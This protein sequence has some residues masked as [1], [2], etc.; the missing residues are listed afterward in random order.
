MKKPILCLLLLVGILLASAVT[1]CAAPAEINEDYDLRTVSGI[2]AEQ[3]APYMH[4]ETRHLAADV[5]RIC[6]EQGV[7]AEFVATVMRWERRPDLKAYLGWTTYD[8]TTYRAHDDEV[9]GLERDIKNIR[10]LY[11]TADGRWFNG[12][13]VFAVSECYNNTKVWRETMLAGTLHILEE[14][15]A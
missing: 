13:T 11:L 8:G 5:V 6:N 1:V 7:S 15:Q 3:L 14:T 4:P 10:N 2:T 9:A 12:Y